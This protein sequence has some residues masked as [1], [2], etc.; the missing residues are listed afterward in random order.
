[1]AST[2]KGNSKYSYQQLPFLSKMG[3][4]LPIASYKKFSCVCVTPTKYVKYFVSQY[5]MFTYTVLL[6][7]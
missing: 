4:P 6:W 7:G 3:Y 5:N 1:M 2:N